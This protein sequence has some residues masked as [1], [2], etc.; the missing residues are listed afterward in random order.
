[1]T[2]RYPFI[3]T[4]SMAAIPILALFFEVTGVISYGLIIASVWSAIAI[5]AV[6]LIVFALRKL[7]LLKYSFRLGGGM[8]F[9]L[10]LFVVG[11]TGILIMNLYASPA[12]PSSTLPVREQLSYM[13]ETDQGDRLALRFRNLNERDHERLE[14]VLEFHEQGNIAHPE[15]LYHAATILQHGTT[16]EHYELAYLLAKRASEAGHENADGLWKAAY[17]RWMLSLG[18]PQVYGTQSTAVFTIFGVSFEQK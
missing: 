14:R 13:Y 15:E 18:K 6:W 8:R 7:H 11:C 3:L 17:D 1:M 4:L 16:S 12:L 2:Q 5:V 10:L 9:P